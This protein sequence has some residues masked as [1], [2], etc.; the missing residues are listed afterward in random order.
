[1]ISAIEKELKYQRTA[2]AIKIRL[3]NISVQ[4]STNA[5]KE[6]DSDSNHDSDIDSTS[7]DSD[8]HDFPAGLECS[9][10]SNTNNKRSRSTDANEQQNNATMSPMKKQAIIVFDKLCRYYLA[11]Q[12]Q[13]DYRNMQSS[14]KALKE[15][16]GEEE[17]V[18]SITLNPLSFFE[19][20]VSEFEAKYGPI[21]LE[22]E[23]TIIHQMESTKTL[24]QETVQN[25]DTVMD[26]VKGKMTL[27]RESEFKDIT[28]YD[29]EYFQNIVSSINAPK[30][31]VKPKEIATRSERTVRTI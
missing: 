10:P 8:D 15:C 6:S 23:Q 5:Q 24:L 17:Q 12:N 9:S 4:R 31:T 3:R 26:E 7:D 25:I 30:C 27:G 1:M 22:M 13:F 28:G 18:M 21:D 19:G 14:L 20:K 16:N 29:L 11:D 2:E